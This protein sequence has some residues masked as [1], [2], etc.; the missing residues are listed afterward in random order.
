MIASLTGCSLFRAQTPSAPPSQNHPLPV[1]PLTLP[2]VRPARI[3]PKNAHVRKPPP[4]L[5][6]PAAPTAP[7]GSPAPTP[8]PVVTLENGQDPKV[9]A[10]QLLDQA[11][12]SLTHF[13]RAE[14]PESTASTYEQASDLIEAAR[15]ALADQDY[16]AASSLAEKASA[17]ISQLPSLKGH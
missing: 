12:V 3:R 5:A 2:T 17:L 16:L 4:T 13:D 14:L 15:H 9:H 1:A 10:Q 7:T 6:T 11:A 8:A